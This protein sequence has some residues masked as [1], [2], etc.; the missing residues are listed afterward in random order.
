MIGNFLHHPVPHFHVH[1]LVRLVII[2]VLAML[3]YL[4]FSDSAAGLIA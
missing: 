3:A 1:H 4:I 2:L